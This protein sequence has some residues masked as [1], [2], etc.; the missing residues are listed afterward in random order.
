MNLSIQT[1]KTGVSQGS[2]VEPLIFNIYIND[3]I[4]SS[5]KFNFILYAEDTTLNSTLES[6]GRT[7]D[8][9]QSSIIVELQK[10]CKWLDLNKLSVNVTKSKFMLFH[11]PQRVAP[12]LHFDL[13]ESPIE[14]VH[15]FNFLGFTLDSSL[16][17][18]FHLIKI[19][20]TISRVVGLLHNLKHIFPSYLLR[21]IYNSLILPHMNYSLLTWDANCHSIELPQKRQL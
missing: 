2:I 18:K 4:N 21:M 17:F 16:S 11:M 20:N 15:E 19:V 8:E 9:I 3:I 13:N 1:I 5:R 12:L 7:T 14:Y 10:I 6:F